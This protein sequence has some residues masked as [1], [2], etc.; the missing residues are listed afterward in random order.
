MPKFQWESSKNQGVIFN[1]NYP[2]KYTESY[3]NW[4]NDKITLISLT[5]EEDGKSEFFIDGGY[6]LNGEVRGL[7]SIV[8]GYSYTQS[9]DQITQLGQ[10]IYE[11]IQEGY[12]LDTI[13]GSSG[14][15]T[16]WENTY[17]ETGIKETITG[18][19]DIAKVNDSLSS[20]YNYLISGN[21]YLYSTNLS[22]ILNAGAGNDVIYSYDG[23]DTINGEDGD[24]RIFAGK[25]ID[26]INGGYGSDTISGGYGDDI[27]NGGYGN[28]TVYYEG[29][30]N[31]YSIEKN[32]NSTIT[33][34]DN[35][36][37][38]NEGSDTL[39]EIEYIQF[40][41]QLLD[42]NDLNKSFAPT[43]IYCNIPS[44]YENINALTTIATLSAID[45]DLDDSHTFLFVDGYTNYLDND[46]FLVE[47]NKLKILSSPD[48]ET[49][50]SYSIAMKV[51]DSNG[52]ESMDLGITFSV[53][54]II[55]E[56]N[57]VQNSYNDDF[58]N[59]IFHNKSEKLFI[60]SSSLYE[61]ITD[62]TTLSFNDRTVNVIGDIKSTF[63]QITG[64]NTDSGQ[65][66]R[67]YNAAFKRLPDPDGLKYWI[68][69][70]SSKIDDE[71]AV[72]S[73]FLA[74][75]EFK[76]RYGENVS[77]AKYVETLY[78]NVLGRNY[79]QDGYNYWLGNLN[80]GT[81]TKHELLLGFAESA[82]NKALFTEMTGFG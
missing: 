14:Y 32:N 5:L 57:Y 60:K 19:I 65:M 53:K 34:S 61:E 9:T 3:N 82:E 24:D 4:L 74:S 1:G 42:I 40:Y 59:Y 13:N 55:D 22:D 76:Q 16:K 48:Y 69:N 73:S 31:Q 20:R 7:K 29:S 52:E 58:T 78:T 51:V 26:K 28:D 63:D 80:N 10:S 43:N 21:D 17:F 18:N 62:I 79:D 46:K 2:S 30:L 68:K 54:N 39:D 45:K 72:A 25:G 41:D 77:N 6:T 47:D 71:R 8:L 11:G 44:F 38:L 75:E 33:I 37:L 49:K 81:E 36:T 70:F 27:I 64:L 23:N 67:L 50:N 12:I 56:T 66:F 35:R 15:L